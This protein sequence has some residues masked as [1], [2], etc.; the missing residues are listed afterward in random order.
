MTIVTKYEIGQTVY[1][2]LDGEWCSGI[3]E[4]FRLKED[5]C[6]CEIGSVVGYFVEFL[7]KR[8]DE[9]TD[10]KPEG[11]E[12]INDFVNLFPEFDLD[13]KSELVRKIRDLKFRARQRILNNDPRPT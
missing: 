5:V 9:V 2:K 7:R 4:S 11:F 13:E 1:F 3:I 10:E 6:Y 8:E 12:Q